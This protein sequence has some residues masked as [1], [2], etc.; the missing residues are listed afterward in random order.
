MSRDRFDVLDRLAPLFQ[1]PEP[2]FE[3]FLRRRDR[4][5]RNQRISAGVVGIAVFVAAIWIVTSGLSLDRTETPGCSRTGADRTDR[6]LRS[7]AP[8]R[9][10]ASTPAEGDVVLQT[11]GSTWR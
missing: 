11:V 7:L 2:S 10:R 8:Q 9:C 3:A 5:R 4:K 6:V 1:A